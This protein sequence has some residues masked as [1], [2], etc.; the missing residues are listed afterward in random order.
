MFKCGPNSIS[1][2]F[3]I[4]STRFLGLIQDVFPGAESS[5][6]SSE[7]LEANIRSVMVEEFGLLVDESQ[8]GHKRPVQSLSRL[9]CKGRY[10]TLHRACCL[11]Y[12]RFER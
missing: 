4:A 6:I 1:F 9:Q 11:F 5:D 12:F 3:C 10:C 7:T 2:L 8:V